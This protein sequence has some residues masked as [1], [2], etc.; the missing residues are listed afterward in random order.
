M[1][2]V[3]S[4]EISQTCPRCGNASW[5][6]RKTRD[7]FRCIRCDYRSDGDRAKYRR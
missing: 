1:V 5:Y 7:W 2:Y 6:N 4:R 3:D